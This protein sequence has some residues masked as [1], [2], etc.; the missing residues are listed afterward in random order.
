MK[1]SRVIAF[2]IS[3]TIGGANIGTARIFKE[4]I[5][6]YPDL[7]NYYVLS[8]LSNNFRIK[9]LFKGGFYYDKYLKI[10]QIILK[11]IFLKKTI[12]NSFFSF[13][14]IPSLIDIVLIFKSRNVDCI[15]L[16]WIG[17]G[18]IS[19]YFFLFL[20][21]T[22]SRKKIVIKFAD[23]F[24]LTGGCHYI[25]NINFLSSS[26]KLKTSPLNFVG[27]IIL[28][29]QKKVF[30]FSLKN[31]KSLTII[32]PSRWMFKKVKE[33]SVFKKSFIKYIPNAISISQSN[34][35]SNK[36]RIFDKSRIIIGI[37][38]NDLNDE[39][40]NL[41]FTAKLINKFCEDEAYKNN[42]G[43]IC[44]GRDSENFINLLNEKIMKNSYF[45]GNLD[46]EI[47]FQKFYL[48][49]DLF[50]HLSLKDNAPNTIMESLFTGVPVFT[51]QKC[52]NAEHIKD[53]YNGFLITNDNI[54]DNFEKL[55][56]T[57]KIL[58][59][60]SSQISKKCIN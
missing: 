40:K 26:S 6:K 13:N 53:S 33:S 44:V 32:T 37:I 27:K 56:S 34:I 36:K 1:K 42:I 10:I 20:A 12:Y 14:I 7:I 19:I 8:K 48:N 11:K 43:I 30:H 3:D 58:S 47:M 2:T 18:S 54:S 57:L 46:S 51:N 28:E 41:Y 22:N 24:Y 52:G 5:E 23:E 4:L 29:F 60:E 16:H 31:L 45:L 17:R 59:K 38:C 35:I 15:Y 21:L 50:L 49:I 9:S 25:N 39:R 55:K